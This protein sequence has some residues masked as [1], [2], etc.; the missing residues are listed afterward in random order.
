MIRFLSLHL[1]P[2]AH[3]RSF[4]IL[5]KV[6]AMNIILIKMM[7]LVLKRWILFLL[8]MPEFLNAR[9]CLKKAALIKACIIH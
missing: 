7:L 9:I 3:Q 4:M 1:Q 2:Y 6:C 5:L 8:I